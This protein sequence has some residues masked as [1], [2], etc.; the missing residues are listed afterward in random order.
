MRKSPSFYMYYSVCR[1]GV[2]RCREVFLWGGLWCGG[3]G[4]G[5]WE[6]FSE[7]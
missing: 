7:G 4:V 3:A 5:P 1:I 6:I 2:R